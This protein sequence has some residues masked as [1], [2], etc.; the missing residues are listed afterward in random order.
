MSEARG[1]GCPCS[2]QWMRTVS[3]R[4]WDFS[5]WSAESVIG[6]RQGYSWSHL[7]QSKGLCSWHCNSNDQQ[8]FFMV[9][10]HGLGTIGLSVCL[11]PAFMYSW[12]SHGKQQEL[13]WCSGM[14]EPK[15][16]ALRSAS[17]SVVLEG[18]VRG[19]FSALRSSALPE[20]LQMQERVVS[21]TTSSDYEQL[22][23][24]IRSKTSEGPI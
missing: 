1:V 11:R 10:S 17:Q 6:R 19:C 21:Q 13:C 18:Y 7:W 23:D 15:G 12:M 16:P 22:Q 5:S 3:T 4:G 20:L 9:V 24:Q 8:C 14:L 2:A